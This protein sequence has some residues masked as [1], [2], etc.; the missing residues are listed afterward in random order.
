MAP[1]RGA[2]L[3]RI[4]LLDDALINR[5]AAGEVVERPASV[6][7]ELVENALDSGVT[8]VRITLDG[9]GKRRVR[10]EDDGHGMDRDDCLLAVE[11]HATSKLDRDHPL[12]GIRS[13]GF[14]GEALPSIAAVSRFLLASA[15]ENGAGT[16]IEIRGGRLAGVRE[17]DRPRGTT[18]EVSALFFNV[19]ARRKFLRADPTELQ[20]AVRAV[21]A[22]ALARPEIRFELVHEGRSLLVLDPASDPIAR[23]PEILGGEDVRAFIPLHAE[24]PGIRVTGLAGRPVDASSRRDPFRFLVNGRP[25]QDRLLSHAV[26]E[27]YGNTVPRGRT[28]RIVILVDVDPEDVDVNVHPQK[29]EVRFARPREVHDAVRDAVGGAL[30]R[31]GAVPVLADLLPNEPPQP[32]GGPVALREPAPSPYEGAP[33]SDS[34]PVFDLPR[35]RRLD[36][37][38]RVQALAQHRDSYIVASDDR[39]LVLVDQHVAHERI[40]YERYLEEAAGDRVSVQRLLFP[41]V[42]DL[43][44]EEALRALEH[45]EELRR[46]GFRFEPFGGNSVRIDAIP[47]LAAG[48]DPA[49]L[50]RELLQ[51]ASSARSARADAEGLRHRFVTTAACKAAIKIH[52][53]LSRD[54]MQRLLEDLFRTAN[55]TTCPHGRPILFRLEDDSIERAFRRR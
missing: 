36:E 29:S 50:L 45:A 41:V 17:I 2:A 38:P 49:G 18:V 4:R 28:P 51:D 1:F 39:G 55:P 19:P 15:A 6:V 21:T 33:R 5:I 25:V 20:H 52:H 27:A 16:E 26:S 40:L 48:L 54:A 53:P 23:A 35:D 31:A 9:G 3:G 47:S 32:R 42:L 11:R 8:S 10:V 14:R 22:A 34:V 44:P 46:L 13:F 7:K 30:S 24:G 12:I 43:P 37:L